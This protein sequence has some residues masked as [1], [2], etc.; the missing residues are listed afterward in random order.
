MFEAEHI[1]V[2]HAIDLPRPAATCLP[3]FTPKGE[4]D[5]IP[6]W[7]PTFLHPADGTT[8][9]GMV[10]TTPGPDGATITWIMTLNDPA[11]GRVRYSRVTPGLAVVTVAVTVRANGTDAS[12]AE[13]GYELVGLS[14]EGNVANRAFA[15]GFVAMIE[16]WR[17]MIHLYFGEAL[18]ALA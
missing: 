8:T 17:R 15:D 3:L 10:F 12:I 13:V 16:D 9:E 14:A 6:T 4:L 7:R 2:R 11:H 5:W 1:N 18:T